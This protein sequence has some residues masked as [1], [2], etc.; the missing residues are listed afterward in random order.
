MKVT[1]LLHGEFLLCGYELPEGWELSR[2]RARVLTPDFCLDQA[3][4]FTIGVHGMKL[5]IVH[6]S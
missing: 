4:G 5:M 6:G 1:L 3:R 2:S